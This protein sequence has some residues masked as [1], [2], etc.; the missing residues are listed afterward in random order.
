VVQLNLT[1][2][3]AIRAVVVGAVM[4]QTSMAAVLL[5][6]TASS[7]A[8]AVAV[9]VAATTAVVVVVPVPPGATETVGEAV[10]A[11]PRPTQAT[12]RW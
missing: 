7:V 12:S 11:S 9:A 3:L 8:V 4:A 1:V 10:P 6:V 2:A 5:L